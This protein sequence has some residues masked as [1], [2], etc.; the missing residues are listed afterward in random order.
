MVPHFVGAREGYITAVRGC[1]GVVP[2][3]PADPAMHPNERGIT[4]FRKIY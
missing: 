2:S 4:L 3:G 1:D